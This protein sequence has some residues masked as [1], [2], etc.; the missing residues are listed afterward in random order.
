[1]SGYFGKLLIIDLGKM[2]IVEKELEEDILYSYLGG[3]GLG[4]YLMMKMLAP[5]EEPL[6]PGNV[7]IF[8]SGPAGNSGLCPSGGYGVFTKSP[9]TGL[10]TEAYCNGY[11]PTLLKKTGY[12]AIV[13]TGV[14]AR[15]SFITIS[16]LGVNFYDASEIWG[17]D[18]ASA[19]EAILGTVGDGDYEAVVIGPAGENMVKTANIRSSRYRNFGRAGIGAVFGSKNLKGIVFRGSAEAG[20]FSTKERDAWNSDFR[21]RCNNRNTAGAIKFYSLTNL[22]T[23]AN[24]RGCFTSGYWSDGRLNDWNK[25]TEKISSRQVNIQGYSCQDC[26]IGCANKTDISSGNDMVLTV[27]DLCYST[28]SALGGLLRITDLEQIINLADQCNRLGLDP[29]SAGNLVSFAIMAGQKGRLDEAP[30]LG[31]FPSIRRFITSLAMVDGP[32]A[33][34]AEGIAEGAAALSLAEAA[35][36]FYG[37]EPAGFDPR[38][39]RM[40]ALVNLVAAFGEPYPESLYFPRHDQGLYSQEN[41]SN[42]THV[43]IEREDRINI[44]DSLLFCRNCHLMVQWEDLI[45]ALYCLTGERYSVADLINLANRITSTIR[46]FNLNEG[47]SATDMIMPSGLLREPVNKECSVKIDHELELMLKDYYLLRGWNEDGVPPLWSNNILNSRRSIKC[48]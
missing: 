33:L 32:G 27:D 13:I 5:G 24:T 19:E 41:Q 9:A 25:I 21:I 22:I 30:I 35:V 20:I 28:A 37:L 14:A 6:S 31:D 15:S 16:E 40:A 38:L 42:I 12:D 39:I 3:K 47:V 18:T 26:F 34:F 45:R 23:T 1:M 17:L 8:A 4:I 11:Q 36:H 43:F 7:I 10:F 48:L 46:L 2:D 44:L 29:I